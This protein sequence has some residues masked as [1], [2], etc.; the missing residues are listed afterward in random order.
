MWK[1]GTERSEMRKSKPAGNIS[2]GKLMRNKYLHTDVTMHFRTKE[3]HTGRY[4]ARVHAKISLSLGGM[5]VGSP[6]LSRLRHRG[7]SQWHSVHLGQERRPRAQPAPSLA[8]P[9]GM[10]QRARQQ[11]AA[12]EEKGQD[13]CKYAKLC[14]GANE[15]NKYCS[16]RWLYSH[17]HPNSTFIPYSSSSLPPK[18]WVQWGNVEL[19]E[20]TIALNKKTL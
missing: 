8:L 5:F 6:V 3:Q 7:D 16:Q 2:P 10:R 9:H 17:K 18:H 19:I 4:L 13:R 1:T 15:A 11:P 20:Q 12:R 14:R